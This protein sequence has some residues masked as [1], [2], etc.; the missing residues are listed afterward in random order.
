MANDEVPKGINRRELVKVGLAVGAAGV[1]T[2][3]GLAVLNPFFQ[4][5]S[6]AV[7]ETNLIYYSQSPEPQWWD[8]RVGEPIRVTDF[9]EWQGA[10]GHWLVTLKDGKPVTG[11]GMPVLVIRVKRDDSVFQAPGR[12]EVPLPSGF[13]LYYDD[14][15]RDI[16]IVAVY[17]RC[18]HLCC[19]PGWQIVQN[20][21]PGRDYVSDAPTYRVYGLDPIYCVCHGS[22]YDPM[23]LVK[24][25]NPRNGVTYIGPS[26]VHGPSPRAIPILPLKADGDFLLGG[27][28]DPRWYVDCG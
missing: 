15:I 7:P 9:Q 8:D 28:A 17:D 18:T 4:R 27:V 2:A 19:F 5:P 22:Q 26:A 23:I 10:T 1:A 11:T 16:R 25:V 24:Q 12:D 3:A 6:E 21:P 13:G 14:P 20:P